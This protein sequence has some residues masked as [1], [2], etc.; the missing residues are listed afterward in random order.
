ML[1]F[2]ERSIKLFRQL[3]CKF[4][5]PG[6]LFWLAVNSVKV[7][8]CKS[9]PCVSRVYDDARTGDGQLLTARE[10]QVVATLVV[11]DEI[12]TLFLLLVGDPQTNHGVDDLQQ[13]ETDN[14]AIDDGRTRTE[15]LADNL[16]ANA[17]TLA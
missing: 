15:E 7:V 17:D 5:I 8:Q 13:D 10:L 16:A 3:R 1:C 14:A 4:R 11:Q 9:G 12:Q 2:F 6:E